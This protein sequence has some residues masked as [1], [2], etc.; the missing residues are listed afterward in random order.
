MKPHRLLLFSWIAWMMF[1]GFSC[2]SPARYTSETQLENQIWN[3]FDIQEYT[4]MP[5]EKATSWD[6]YFLFDHLDSYYTDHITVNITF[7]LPQGGMRS[8]DYTFGLKNDALDW[9]GKQNG[10]T[11]AHQLPVIKG[12]SFD[13]TGPLKIRVESKMTKF[14]LTD[15]KKVG[16]LM[17]ETEK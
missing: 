4:I 9:T 11:I 12:F 16:I 17:K 1:F 6:V 14:N 8:R 10:K 5:D 15:V 7:Y 3:R 13:E 2:K